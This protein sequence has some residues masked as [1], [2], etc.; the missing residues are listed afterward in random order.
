M[1]SDEDTIPPVARDDVTVSPAHDERTVSPMDEEKTVSPTDDDD[2]TVSPKDEEE[3]TRPPAAVLRYETLPD[4]FAAI[5]QVS[6]MMHARPRPPEGVQDFLWRLRR[7]DTPEEGVTLTAF[8][9][10][11][12]L[13][14]WWGHECL[15]TIPEV[16]TQTDR[17]LM[18]MIAKWLAEP[19]GENRHAIMK[20]ALW[21]DSRSPGVHLGL[22]V[23]WSGGSIAPN[24]PAPVPPHRCPRAINTAVL[25]CL[26][27]AAISRRT[28]YLTRFMDV[29]QSL[30]KVY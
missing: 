29:A 5:P 13:A 24:D 19:T 17:D 18:D 21:A 16:L 28:I 6:E 8:A 20:E 2:K 26:A 12:K 23:G 10:V 30:F 7:S 11:P 3:K 25:T 4:L 15:R 9:F 27:S 1:M 14:I 22:A